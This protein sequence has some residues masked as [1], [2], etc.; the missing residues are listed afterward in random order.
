MAHLSRRPYHRNAPTDFTKFLKF[1][2]FWRRIAGE[3]TW[4]YFSDR[5][6]LWRWKH[7]T[8]YECKLWLMM[9]TCKCRS[10]REICADFQHILQRS[11][12]SRPIRCRQCNAAISRM[13]TYSAAAASARMTRSHHGWMH[14]QKWWASILVPSTWYSPPITVIISRENRTPAIRNSDLWETRAND[15]WKS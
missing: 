4:W 12:A 6:D 2:C 3:L 8:E 10:L 15:G 1:S 14:T 13:T 7:E 11:D 5:T 9:P